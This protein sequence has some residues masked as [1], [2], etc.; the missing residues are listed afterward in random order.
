MKLKYY[1]L[2]IVCL[3]SSLFLVSCGQNLKREEVFIVGT[4]AAYP[5]FEYIDK[6]GKIVGFDIDVAEAVS[7]KLNKR[8]EIR[9]FSFDA[10]LLNLKRNRV[11]AVISGMSITPSRKKEIVMIPYYGEGVYSLTAISRNNITEQCV[12]PL[13]QYS[14][15]AVQTGTYQEDYLRSLPNVAIRS[16]D[17]ALEV[18][19]E[20]LGKKSPLAVFEPSVARVVLKDFPELHCTQI[21]LPESWWVLGYGIGISKDN[22]SL[23]QEVSQAIS[24]LKTEGVL[25]KL[26][27]K[28]GL[29]K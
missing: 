18:I 21:C 23:V 19:M 8:L 26:E 29:S 17:S 25:H 3:S 7:S 10:L 24:E 15:V 5:P 6:E 22:E 28:W 14:S 12:V 2:L 1:C 11:D 16:F 9:D 20:V 4:N 27:E 13:S